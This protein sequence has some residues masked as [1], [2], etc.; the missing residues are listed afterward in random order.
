MTDAPNADYG[1]PDS[2]EKGAQHWTPDDHPPHSWPIGVAAGWRD[3]HG[4]PTVWCK[5]E[6]SQRDETYN[7]R[8]NLPAMGSD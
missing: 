1:L 2:A 6:G 8:V 7:T 4:C 3:G 5:G